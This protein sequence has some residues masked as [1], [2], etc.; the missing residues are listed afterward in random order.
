MKYGMTICGVLVAGAALALVAA[1]P[2]QDAKAKEKAKPGASGFTAEQE[3]AWAR[4]ATPG[5]E[6]KALADMAGQW[7]VTSECWMAPDAPPQT[8][9]GTATMKSIMGGRFI[10]E[11]FSGTLPMGPFHG[12]GLLGFNNGTKEY[13]HVWL[14]DMGTGMM[15]TKGEVKGDVVTFRGEGFCPMTNGP[16]ATRFEVRKLTDS[17]RTLTFFAQDEGKPEF[18]TMELHYKRS[19]QTGR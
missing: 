15:T 4:Y 14:D 2:W 8:G 3:A 16:R 17:E 12:L 7:V 5:A 10:E 13:E 6:H 11:E 19:S 1:T 9:S 18:K